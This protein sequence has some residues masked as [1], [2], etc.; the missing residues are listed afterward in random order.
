MKL[1]GV[2]L[3][4][5]LCFL[6]VGTVS[7]A[8]LTV[9][10]GGSIQSVIDNASS[11]DTI[12]VNDNNGHVYTYNENI[13]I[14][15]KLTLQAKSG[16]L[17]AIRALDS[18][19]P[20][21]RVNSNG[22]GSIIKGF[23]ISG[24]VS[25]YNDGILLDQ[26]SNCNISGNNIINKFAGIT[27]QN[28]KNNTV[29]GNNLNANDCGI[30]IYTSDNNLITGNNITNSMEI[31][32]S[33]DNSNNNV[34]S[35]N[36]VANNL[37]GIYVYYYSLSN[38]IN[39]NRIYGNT[40]YGLYCYESIDVTNNWWGSNA[41]P[42]LNSSNIYN[43]GINTYAPWIVL[44]TTA[45]F[46]DGNIVV[47]ADLTHNSAG[48]DT[49][50]QGHVPDNIP[51]NFTTMSGTVT[52]VNTRNGKASAI[53]DLGIGTI[54]V[55]VNGESIAI[56][57]RDPVPPTVTANLAGG[58][59]N[60]TKT[61]TLTA[62][63][64]VDLN[65]RI[66]YS[67]DNGATWNS[68]ARTVTLNLNQGITNLK[69]YARD[70]MSNAC[71]NQ[72]ITY[73]IDLTAPTVTVNPVGGVYNTTKNVTLTASDNFDSNPVVY[74]SINNGSTWSSHVKTVT[75]SLGQGV[76][77]LKYYARDNAG[78]VCLNQTVS[79]TI[80]LTAPTVTV[81]P[82][83]GVYNTT[84]N[85]TLTVSDN[86]DSNPVVYYS[87]NNGTTW[88]SKVKTVTLNL[89]QGMTN[90]KFYA[91]DSAG[92]VCLNQT[93]SY[94]ID[95]TA[96]TVTANPAGG[97]YNSPQNVILVASDNLDPYPKIYYT[98][99]GSTP[100]ISSTRYTNPINITNTATLKFI[101]VDN[102][103][104][105]GQVNIGQYNIR[106]PFN[107]TVEI[108]NSVYVNKG[109]STVKIFPYREITITMINQSYP[110]YWS[111]PKMGDTNYNGTSSRPNLFGGL[112]Y[113][114][115]EN[116]N[117][118][119]ID[120]LDEIDSPGISLYCS[121]VGINM[122]S[123][124]SG[125][126]GG[127]PSEITYHGYLTNG[128][129]QFSAIFAQ[130]KID[131]VIPIPETESIYLNLNG[132][133]KVIISFTMA[134]PEYNDY[135]LRERLA[136]ENG[137]TLSPWHTGYYDY[138]PYTWFRDDINNYLRFSNTNESLFVNGNYNSVRAGPSKEYI[139][140]RFSMNN[141]SIE[142][143]ETVTYGTSY[144]PDSS[145]DAGFEAIQ[146]FA[147]TNTKITDD[148]VQQ[149]LNKNTTY[150]VGGLKAAYG[151]FMTALTTLWLSD[152]IAG[153]ISE[154]LNGTWSRITP[155]VVMSGVTGTTGGKAY[156]HC[157]DPGMGMSFLGDESNLRLFRFVCSLMLSEVEHVTLGSAGSSVNSTLLAITSAILNGEEYKIIFNEDNTAIF[158]LEGDQR[159][160]IVID[161]E[162]G[163]VKEI[164]DTGNFQ[165]KGA[166]TVATGY[167]YHDQLTE[168]GIKRANAFLDAFKWGG[169][170]STGGGLLI[171]AG[172][173]AFG[174]CPPL[175]VA[176]LGI[177]LFV[178]AD[179]SGLTQ[180]PTNPYNWL[181]FG[182][183]AGLSLAGPEGVTLKQ[184]INPVFR[185]GMRYAVENEGYKTIVRAT[186]GDTERSAIKGYYNNYVTGSSISGM[187]NM[188]RPENN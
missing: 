14:N 11:N 159:F 149:W 2:F 65:P 102:A 99:N 40:Q 177:G 18:S 24:N 57:F 54:T 162:T 109:S 68:Q 186:V 8:N 105:Q 42:T 49:S 113:F 72:T 134:L 50:S 34:I 63:D 61:V 94:T 104:N 136:V 118:R 121:Q 59:Y 27:L 95:F 115:P 160:K 128:T 107:Y 180:D 90:L 10:P 29:S 122:D 187:I 156:V 46:E 39:F 12:T 148:M 60:T 146:T 144:T 108:P 92:N 70:S 157:P 64:N 91:R 15:K 38:R 41:N 3:I 166:E 140:T 98:L 185:Q 112:I 133:N 179:A 110:F 96:P 175:G 155:T 32:I 48:N 153:E 73:T 178:T 176:M 45:N 138:A 97:T 58:A 181:D 47:T 137:Y 1:K 23:T 7:A 75:L 106:V 77:N 82:V 5:V 127:W 116:G 139:T 103:G 167:C 154:N 36:D 16:G 30:Y 145:V 26:C 35:G 93:V 158:T 100:T 20:T 147:I 13:V 85:V 150:P 51:V 151:T 88:N 126:I 6:S 130:T 53:Y 19:L 123:I 168:N 163:L 125:Y 55:T 83:G 182:V 84:K 172:L 33:I 117:M 101:A 170:E 25:D 71:S 67:L 120:S 169:V 131:G 161:L 171:T 111:Y 80:D 22:N 173:V 21:V 135:I 66:Y 165:Y 141:C 79:Y 124:I 87:T 183:S 142:K 56:N 174:A 184:A 9:N 28:S 188:Y 69:F 31:G 17:V 86:F 143:E 76:T 74:Y 114:I 78:N 129:N 4:L 44:S 152:K 89:S 164:L 52:T 119:V 37:C 62:S 81:N 43:C 132:V